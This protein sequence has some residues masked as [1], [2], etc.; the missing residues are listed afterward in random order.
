VQTTRRP[1]GSA[2]DGPK[3]HRLLALFLLCSSLLIVEAVVLSTRNPSSLL[4]PVGVFAAANA[5]LL[6]PALWRR[7]LRWSSWTATAR[8]RHAGSAR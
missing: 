8:H 3:R 7:R 1:A 2:Q 5:L 4:L 6:A